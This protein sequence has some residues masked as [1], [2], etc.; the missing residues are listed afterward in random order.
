M[1]RV[2]RS[3]LAQ[4]WVAGC[5]GSATFLA[6]VRHFVHPGD[7]LNK[8]IE[9]GPCSDYHACAPGSRAVCDLVCYNR[10]TVESAIVGSD[11]SA[12]FGTI[13]HHSMPYLY[14]VRPIAPLIVGHVVVARLEPIAL[15][16]PFAASVDSIGLVHRV[17]DCGPSLASL[18]VVV[19]LGDLAARLGLHRFPA[20]IVVVVSNLSERV[21]LRLVHG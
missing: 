3:F 15:A 18:W 4:N 5:T 14:S 17:V 13:V 7:S 11:T 6:R 16:R 10:S 12:G 20:E 8:L 19:L 2:S 21:F 9:I 1:L